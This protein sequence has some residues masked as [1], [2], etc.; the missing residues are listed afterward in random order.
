M[1]A[2]C[3]LAPQE[4]IS[5]VFESN[6]TIFFEENAAENVICKLVAILFSFNVFNWNDIGLWNDQI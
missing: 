2:Y 4:Q 1:L 6:Y 5:V 3:Q